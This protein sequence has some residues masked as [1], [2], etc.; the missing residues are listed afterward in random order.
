MLWTDVERAF[1]RAALLSFSRK[2]MLLTL[3]TLVVC[4]ILTVFCR[5]LAYDAGDWMALSLTFF[6]ILLCSGLLLALGSLLAKVHYHEVKALSVNMRRLISGSLE[7]MMGTSYLS[8]PPLLVY[9]LFWI[10]LGL[11][12]LL[13]EMPGVGA[14]FS[15]IFSFSPF[16][17]IFFFL[18]LF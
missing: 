5:A 15:V 9:L 3:P 4:G 6:P 12:F 17:F 2:K 1:N 18:F 13:K 11:F 16:L 10:A 14:F 8:I 7:V